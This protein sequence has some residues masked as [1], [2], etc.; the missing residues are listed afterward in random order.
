[1]G[2]VIWESSIE[3]RHFRLVERIDGGVTK[4]V[5]EENKGPDALD[6]PRWDLPDPISS[7][8]IAEIMVAYKN[9]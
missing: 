7:S 8:V 1:M 6:N 9:A 2:T 4:F 3:N 5:L